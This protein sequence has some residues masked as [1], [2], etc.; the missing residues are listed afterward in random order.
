[1]QYLMLSGMI[2]VFAITLGLCDLTVQWLN[3]RLQRQEMPLQMPPGT[4]SCLP[5]ASD[6]LDLECSRLDVD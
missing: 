6:P 1:M 4:Y 5:R 3:G 2:A